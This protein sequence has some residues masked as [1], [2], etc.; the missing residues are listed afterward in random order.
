MLLHIFLMI[1]GL[2]ALTAG[3]EGLVRGSSSL[4]IRMGLTPLIIGLTV[5]AFGTSTPEL[6]VSLSASLN[7]QA[8]IAIGNVVGSNIFNIG[9][10][11]GITALLCPVKVNLQVIKHDAPIM[12]GVSLLS[13]FLIT[14]GTLSRLTGIGLFVMLVA[15]L[16]YSIR[17]ARKEVS[18]D[19]EKQFQEGVPSRSKSLYRDLLFIGGGLL[20][21]VTGSR[22]LVMSATDIARFMGISEA[23]IGL[24][25]I[26]AGTSMPELATSIMAAFRRQPDIAVGNVVGSNIFNL[27]GIMGAASIASPLSATGITGL[28][29]WVMVGFS[30]ALLPLLYTGLKLQRWEG[31]L[32]L[33]GYAGYLWTLWP[34]S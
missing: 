5:V 2:T 18:K 34:S 16:Y 9:I 25:I 22:L 1:L 8:D 11:L 27:L 32:L 13:L 3:A 21:L 6:V 29:L 24:T 33:L 12:I 10:I 7:N 15:Y 30:M 14:K 23:V 31:A 4:A 26:S 28:D 20:L 19:I 17:L